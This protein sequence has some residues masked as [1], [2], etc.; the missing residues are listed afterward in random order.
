MVGVELGPDVDSDELLEVILEGGVLLEKGS[1]GA[2][3]EEGTVL[4]GSVTL[5]GGEG[6]VTEEEC[7]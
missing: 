3:G 4:G 7:E 5:T 2:N 6:V 1:E